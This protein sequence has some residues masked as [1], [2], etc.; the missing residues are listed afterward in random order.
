VSVAIL[1]LSGCSANFSPSNTFE[2]EQVEI[3][4][5]QGAVHGGQAPV[6][7]AHVYLFAA[8][9]T[10]YGSA[11]TSLITTS[12]LP[13]GVSVDGNGNGYVTT[14]A[15]GN[16]ALSGDYTC[17]EGTQVY[18]VAVGGDA[19]FG[20][21][22][23]IVQ[24][25]GLGECP[26]AGNLAQQDPYVVINEVS[27]VAFAYAMA[28]FVSGTNTDA[29]HIG[30]TSTTA[31]KLAIHNAMA[32][33]N[34][35]VSLASGLPLSNMPAN[36]DATVP[37]AKIYH[38][39]NILGMCVNTS[40]T[41]GTSKERGKSGNYAYTL[42]PCGYLFSYTTGITEA[43]GD[44]T[45]AAD[46]AQAI[47][48]IA[49][50]PASAN[51]TNLYNLVQ[52]TSA[53]TDTMT[54]APN[55]WTLPIV[56]KNAVSNFAETNGSYTSGPFN[57]AIDASGNAWI[58]DRA[59]GVV[60]I[61]TQGVLTN[62]Y[63][64]SSVMIKGVS[65]DP[66]G[67]IWAADYK[68]SKVY[69][70]STSGTISKTLTTGLNGPSFVAFNDA[71][72]AYIVNEA[73]TS[74]TVYVPTGTSVLANAVNMNVGNGIATPAFLAIDAYGDAWIADTGG[75]TL[76]ELKTNYSTGF[77]NSNKVG[78]AYWLGFDSSHNMWVGDFGNQRLDTGTSLGNGTYTLGNTKSGG[79]VTTPVLGEID[80]SGTVWMPD[81][82]VPPN[83][84]NSA[85]V[86]SGYS[87]GV[88]NG[89]YLATATGGFSTGCSVSVCPVSGGGGLGGSV[90][91]A[92]DLSGNVW[93]A[94][95]DGTVSEL[96]GLGAPTASPITPSNTGT[97]P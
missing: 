11:S 14:G 1:L 80:G 84:L 95:E 88:T 64:D 43:N 2:P 93:V 97:E 19:G 51:V 34:N 91:A 85:S 57:I 76:G 21:N 71:G 5:I 63:H 94:N 7:G 70:M 4:P 67:N 12:P 78:G 15:G 69:I 77:I 37:T 42:D 32:N 39:A 45:T 6:I 79:G 13:S 86:L 72:D 41:L 47:F 36:S 68:N 26:S 59:D 83:N 52:G 56:Y 25:A 87:G 74:M 49:L 17:T 30:S 61:S 10:G 82:I 65:I 90:A 62:P 3:G 20:A 27:T 33:T 55:D 16:F 60:E 66:S 40:G 31:G 8:G 50:N 81:M 73:P 18:M 92:V 44:I 46:E 38:L 22:Q 75:G 23:Y 48:N 9:S 29:Y 53:F 28:R 89:A 54:G 35:L 96:I 58:G 24:M